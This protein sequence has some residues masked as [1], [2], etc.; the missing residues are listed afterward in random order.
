MKFS[1][2]TDVLFLQISAHVDFQAEQLLSS[3]GLLQ[4]TQLHLI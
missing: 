2:E 4:Y 3:A 1:E